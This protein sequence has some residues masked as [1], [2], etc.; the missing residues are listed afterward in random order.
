MGRVEETPPPPKQ[1]F[2]FI[3]IRKQLSYILHEIFSRKSILLVGQI[4]LTFFMPVN[5][6]MKASFWGFVRT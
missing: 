1:T 6:D 5:F 3:L 2:Q 4:P